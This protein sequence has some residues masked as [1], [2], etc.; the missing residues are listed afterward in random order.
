MIVIENLNIFSLIKILFIKTYINYKLKDYQIYYINN[1]RYIRFYKYWFFLAFSIKLKRLDF[2]H[3]NLND[4]NDTNYGFYGIER[5]IYELINSINLEQYI[6]DECLSHTEKAF[7]IG[8]I[9]KILLGSWPGQGSASLRNF[10]MMIKSIRYFAK[11]RIISKENT[12]FLL[13]KRLWNNQLSIFAFKYNI[14]LISVT[15]P[16]KY[17]YQYVLNLL[18]NNR[19]IL[20]MN[21]IVEA[22]KVGF[23]KIFNGL[24]INSYG[25]NP[26][27]LV[28]QIYQLFNPKIFWKYNITPNDIVFV[29]K[30]H[31]INQRELNEIKDL[32]MSYV[33]LSSIVSEG[34]D[35]DYYRSDYA[36][37]FKKNYFSF[38]KKVL[39]HNNEEIHVLRT[40]N[41]YN[42][43][44]EYWKRL[45][46]D[47]NAKIYMSHDK[48]NPDIICAAAAM[49][50]NGGISTILQTSYY[51]FPTCHSA[52]YTD[53]FFSYSTNIANVEKTLASE[54]KYIVCTGFIYEGYFE[55]KKKI[56]DNIRKGLKRNG[57]KL[58]ICLIDGGSKFDERWTVGETNYRSDY[59]FWLEKI[60]EETWLGVI[61]KSKGPGSLRK[62]LGPVSELLSMAIDTGRC[63]FSDRSNYFDKNLNYRVA[64]AALASDIA[65]HFC[66]YAGTGGLEAKLV[67]TPTLFFDRF[68]LKD[69]QFY[70]LGL[71]E[72]VF[73]NWEKMWKVIKGK[74]ERNQIPLIGDWSP[75]IDDID[76]FRD[77]KAAYRMNT[78]LNWLL[79]GFKKGYSRGDVLEMTAKRYSL[80]WGEDKVITLT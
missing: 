49:K 57:A 71:N 77:G 33:S 18:K 12:H 50:D 34:I 76:P 8:Y 65:I 64:D 69:S 60:L 15:D 45:F 55:S 46:K 22:Y 10:L 41:K 73:N 36:V 9:V 75:I 21:G 19:Y 72:V 24:N 74:I 68:G 80:E 48:W 5:D 11:E 28:E 40:L 1:S 39:S 58:I 14:S 17:L 30:F 29:N 54:I 7:A 32:G 78:Y 37:Y 66:L 31:K 44:I 52:M 47:V 42:R 61:I 70:K 16:F 43:R 62:R 59:K 35:A 56:S 26:K 6:D 51:E 20:L 23:D 4:E 53:V 79:E 27:I 13:E 2:K 67:G 38:V 3:D 25:D 63:H